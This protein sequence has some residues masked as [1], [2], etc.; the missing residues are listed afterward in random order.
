NDIIARHGRPVAAMREKIAAKE[1]GAGFFEKQPRIPAMRQMRRVEMANALA[2]EIEGLVIAQRA[3]AIGQIADP[4]PA[5]NRPM[6][7]GGAGRRLEPIRERAAF[8]GLDMAEAYPAQLSDGE[9]P[10]DGFGD[11]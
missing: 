9:N 4:D 1:R 8:I 6:H 5:A 7:D 11:L 3:Q 10:R 2:A